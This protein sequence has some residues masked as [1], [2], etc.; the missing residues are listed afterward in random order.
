MPA[1]GVV[2]ERTITIDV[3]LGAFVENMSDAA[4]LDRWGEFSAARI[5]NA[6]RRPE[7]LFD[8]VENDAFARLFARMI[9]CEAAMV[10]RMP[11]LRRHD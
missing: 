9:G 10:W 8:A 7:N 6:M 3:S 11:I 5:L 4:G 1:M 2:E